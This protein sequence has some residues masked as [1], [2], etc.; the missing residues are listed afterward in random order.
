MKRPLFLIAATA[1]LLMMGLSVL[2][3]ILAFYID[4][5]GLTRTQSGIL[6]SIY[7][8]LSV[9]ASP[10]WGWFSQ[11]FGRKPAIIIGL[12]GF[13]VGFGLFGLGRNFTELLAARMLGGLFA[14]AALPAIFAYVADVTEPRERSGAMGVVGAAIGLGIILGPGFGGILGQFSLRLP[15][16]ASAGLGLL[17]ALLVAIWLPESRPREGEKPSYSRSWLV[18]LL[19]LL[20][21]GVLISTARVGF[22]SVF[23][24]LVKDRFGGG[25]ATVGVL[26]L[27][28]GAVGVAV[29]GG[30][31][32][33]LSR[34]FS[35]R[36]LL[37]VSTLLLAIGLWGLGYAGSWTPL[38]VAGS[39]LAIGYGLSLPVFTSLISKLGRD[40]QGESQGLGQSAQSI[41][42]VIG[43]IAFSWTYDVWGGTVTFGAAAVLSLFAL[44][45][46]FIGVHQPD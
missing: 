41:G 43:P 44:L 5:L 8:L 25:T 3:P 36:V 32:R 14:A 20:G 42:R 21:Y 6:L 39:I 13:A 24:F 2:F 38:A 28:I 9:V 17:T 29:Q 46:A 27:V 35:D 26:L 22:E 16:F 37:L 23:G 33:P 12:L 30:A 45:V 34:R 7:A 18:S 31:V 4:W 1:C 10:A 11:R 40:V 15:F 19:P